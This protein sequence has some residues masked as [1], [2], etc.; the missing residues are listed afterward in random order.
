VSATI[1]RDYVIDLVVGNR[2][3]YTVHFNFVVIANDATLSRPT[4][5]Q[6]AAR[7]LAIISFECRVEALM[8][9]I[10]AHPVVPFL[11]CCAYRKNHGHRAAK[12]DENAPVRSVTPSTGISDE[13]VH[14]LHNALRLWRNTS[15][16]ACFAHFYGAFRIAFLWDCDHPVLRSLET[17]LHVLLH[18]PW[19]L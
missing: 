16:H 5:H 2:R 10:M 8:P 7:A 3:P 11:R 12:G 6:I 17:L 18:R 13:G 19:R 15:R 4:I 9:F 1:G 14:F